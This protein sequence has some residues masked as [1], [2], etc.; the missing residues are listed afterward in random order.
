MAATGNRHHRTWTKDLVRQAMEAWE[1]KFGRPP[2]EADWNPARTKLLVAGSMA[3]VQRAKEVLDEF[4]TGR[5]PSS[6]TVQDM[7]DGKWAEG[8]KDAGFVPLPSGRPEG[9]S[10]SKYAKRKEG[11]DEAALALTYELALDALRQGS[12]TEKRQ[13]LLDLSAVA[14]SLAEEIKDDG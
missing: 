4:A 1:I 7:Y 11:V 8:V 5:Y 12:A 6:R 14:V 9:S 13:S 2:T 10:Y 3:R